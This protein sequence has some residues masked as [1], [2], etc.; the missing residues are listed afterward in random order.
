MS[1]SDFRLIS[2]SQTNLLTHN[3]FHAV[4]LKIML[5]VCKKI[6][7]RKKINRKEQFF[8]VYEVFENYFFFFLAGTFFTAFFTGASS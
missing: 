8:S 3:G 4:I 5:K 2:F 6:R 1:K 7:S